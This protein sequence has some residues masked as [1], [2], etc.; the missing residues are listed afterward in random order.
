MISL[1]YLIDR[2]LTSLTCAELVSVLKRF[3]IKSLATSKK[4]T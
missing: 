4:H 1:L 2:I 3:Y